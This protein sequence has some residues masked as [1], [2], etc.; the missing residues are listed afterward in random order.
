MVKVLF[1]TAVGFCLFNVSDSSKLEATKN[2]HE[3]LDSA[4]GAS[5]L[6]KLSAIHRFTNTAEAVEDISAIN[7]GKMSKSLKK[8]LTE[9]IVE[10]KGKEKENLIVA[11]SKLGTLLE[12]RYERNSRDLHTDSLHSQFIHLQ[13]PTLPRSSASTSLTTA[14]SSTFTV[15]SV[16][17]SLLFFP[18]LLAT[19]SS[20]PATLTP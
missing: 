19:S 8:F 14:S 15:V 7:E 5:N 11:E 20:T 18:R 6:L 9:E 10:G 3:S 16:R 12:A 13:L 4:E 17:T 1:E 2:L